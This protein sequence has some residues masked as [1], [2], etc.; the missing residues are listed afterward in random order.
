MI[1][2]IDLQGKVIYKEEIKGQEL[3][4]HE[5]QLHVSKGMYITYIYTQSG[6]FNVKTLVR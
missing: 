1:Q 4:S 6:V 2:V 5:I 3:N